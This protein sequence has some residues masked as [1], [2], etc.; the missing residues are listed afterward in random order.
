MNESIPSA[1]EVAAALAQLTFA[2][3][4]RL[5]SISGVPLT[6]V[7]KIKSGETTNPGIETVRKFAR[8]IAQ[9]QQEE[10]A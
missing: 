1:A 10:A 5:A 3:L 7:Y 8:F 2:Q 4:E 9:A 6:T